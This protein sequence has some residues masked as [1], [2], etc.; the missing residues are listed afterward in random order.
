M[1]R[2]CIVSPT[3][4]RDL[5]AIL[6]YFFERSIEAGEMF[7]TK[8]EQKCRYLAKF[9]MMGRRYPEVSPELRGI[10]LNGYVIFYKVTDESIEIARLSVVIKI[11]SL[12]FQT[13]IKSSVPTKCLNPKYCFEMNRIEHEWQQLKFQ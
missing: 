10:P 13:R 3:A 8:F 11:S 6:D 9:P 4:S 2:T 12:Y 7:A 1:S 5:A